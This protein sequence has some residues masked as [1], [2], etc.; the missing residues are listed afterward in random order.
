[1]QRCSTVQ[2]GSIQ[3][4]TINTNKGRQQPKPCIPKLKTYIQCRWKAQC[5]YDSE[6][7]RTLLWLW[8]IYLFM[9]LMP[10]WIVYL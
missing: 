4:K 8:V 6:P 5:V 10:G 9:L 7:A 2:V 3:L 1:M